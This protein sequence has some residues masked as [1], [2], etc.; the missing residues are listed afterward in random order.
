[1]PDFMNITTQDLFIINCS[2][3]VNYLKSSE[4]SQKLAPSNL[5]VYKM[6]WRNMP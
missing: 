2:I 1:M 3:A 4:N 5:Y 6:L